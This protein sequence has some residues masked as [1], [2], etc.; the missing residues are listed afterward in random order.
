MALMIC[1][2]RRHRGWQG[3][4]QV[5]KPIRA[6]RAA[7]LRH[8]PSS[9]RTAG[10]AVPQIFC[11]RHQDLGCRT[12][13]A[14]HGL[15]GHLVNEIWPFYAP[16]LR[17]TCRVA[18]SHSLR[19]WPLFL[20]GGARFGSVADVSGDIPAQAQALGAAQ[21]TRK[22]AA[23]LSRDRCPQS[24]DRGLMR[25]QFG[26][27][28]PW[29]RAQVANISPNCSFRRQRARWMRLLTVPISQPRIS[30]ASI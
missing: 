21:C 22:I 16:W 7:M 17:L 30:A 8:P 9:Q 5:Y 18:R 4:R 6:R 15:H 23:C 12:S 29:R 20:N 3:L 26:M 10:A 14:Q 19:R 2:R 11:P 24:C 1:H 27:P 13:V 28:A 25:R